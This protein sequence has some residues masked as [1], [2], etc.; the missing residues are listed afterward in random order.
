MSQDMPQE[1]GLPPGVLNTDSVL[2]LTSTQDQQSH[3][4]QNTP[5]HQTSTSP[6]SLSQP[7]NVSTTPPSTH[8]AA[9]TPPPLSRRRHRRRTRQTTL[10]GSPRHFPHTSHY[11]DNPGWKPG[12]CIRDVFCNIN[13]MLQ[14]L[15]NEKDPLMW[16]ALK[17]L[18]KKWANVCVTFPTRVIPNSI[19]IQ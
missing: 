14:P 18:R 9:P 6:P 12:H 3:S 11:G 1:S 17:D 16:Q 8:P 10:T 5:P 2:H 19:V 4:H 7:T 15:H 13:G